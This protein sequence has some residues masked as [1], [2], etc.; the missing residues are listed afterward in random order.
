M[1]NQSAQYNL[2][3]IIN[4]LKNKLKINQNMIK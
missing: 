4:K 3:Q 1:I 2:L